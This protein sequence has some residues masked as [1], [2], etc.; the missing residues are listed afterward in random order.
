MVVLFFVLFTVLYVKN[1]SYQRVLTVNSLNKRDS[2][3]GHLIE[4]IKFLAEQR[5]SVYNEKT[6]KNS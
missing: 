1:K 3:L 5:Y 2:F 6:E 4:D